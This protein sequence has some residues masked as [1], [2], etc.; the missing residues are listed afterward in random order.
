MRRTL[1][2]LAVLGLL[3]LGLSGT[4]APVE[5]TEASWTHQ[6]PARSATLSAATVPPVASLSCTGSLLLGRLTI[7]WTHAPGTIPRQGYQIQR[8]ASSSSTTPTN[9]FT[10][11]PNATQYVNSNLALLSDSRWEVR[12]MGPGQWVSAPWAMHVVQ[13]ATALNCTPESGPRT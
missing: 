8:F 2:G 11:G 7:N 6:Q 5:Q 1:A 9:T 3:S 4:A 13:L 10:V 12:T